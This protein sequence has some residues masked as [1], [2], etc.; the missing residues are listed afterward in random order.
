MDIL[1]E[2]ILNLLFEGAFMGA[3]DRRV[4]KPIRIIFLVFLALIYGV[5]IAAVEIIGLQLISEG[6]TAGGIL[7]LL[8]ALA[9]AALVVWGVIS[10]RRKQLEKIRKSQNDRWQGGYF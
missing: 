6:K 7:V 8:C 5:I 10:E 3:T 2:F 4:P 1:I 9:V